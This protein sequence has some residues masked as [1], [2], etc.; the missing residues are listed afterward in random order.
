[1]AHYIGKQA[2]HRYA[3]RYSPKTFTQRQLFACLVLKAFFKTDYRGLAQLLH[4][5]PELCAVIELKRVPHF[6]TFQKA[7]RRSMICARFDRL[8]Q[9][10]G[11]LGGVG[12]S[13]NPTVKR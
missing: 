6:T 7:A 12:S 11:R 2:L 8:L 3:H 10:A 4:D 5:V 9:Q 13:F 1:M